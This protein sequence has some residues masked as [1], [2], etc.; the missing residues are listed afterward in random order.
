MRRLVKV[1]LGRR[2]QHLRSVF[3]ANGYP[4]PQIDRILRNRPRPPPLQTEPKTRPPPSSY[5]STTSEESCSE[6]IERV[7]RPLGTR[8]TFKSRALREAMVRTK[9]PHPV[10]KKEGVMYQAPCAECDCAH[11]GETERSL[12]KRLSEHR[13]AVKRNDTKNGI[14]VYAWKTQHKVDWDAA[15]VKQVETNYVRR[16]TIKAIHIKRREVTSN[17]D[18]GQYL[19]PVWHPLICPPEHNYS[20]QFIHQ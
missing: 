4:T 1:K 6:R 9:E 7:C 8:T 15:T 16:R 10:R 2:Q 3:Q 19:S 20:Q 17:L 13:G 14:A 11:I 12:E 18:R 5:I